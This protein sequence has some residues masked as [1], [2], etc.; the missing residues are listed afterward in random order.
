MKKLLLLLLL[1]SCV[2]TEIINK[3]QD[4]DI[5][6]MK[7]P[8]KPMPPRDTTESHDTSRIPI[9]FKP[10]VGGWEYSEIGL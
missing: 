2:K 9:G 1:T 4:E 3:H 5:P 8:H 7:K 6:V 10:N